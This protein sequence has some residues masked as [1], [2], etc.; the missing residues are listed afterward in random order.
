MRP[1]QWVFAQQVKNGPNDELEILFQILRFWGPQHNWDM[2]NV[3]MFDSRHEMKAF[4]EKL[5]R[6]LKWNFWMLEQMGMISSSAHLGFLM[7]LQDACR[8]LRNCNK[9]VLHTINIS[10]CF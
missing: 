9:W 4:V 6:I 10:V 2:H 3:F 1:Q 7:A 5:K 8:R